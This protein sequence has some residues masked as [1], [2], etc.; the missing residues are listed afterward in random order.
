MREVYFIFLNISDGNEAASSQMF[1]IIL[2]RY[3]ADQE[4]LVPT[5]TG[6]PHLS[7]WANNPI[8][9]LSRNVALLWRQGIFVLIT[10]C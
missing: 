7:G 6:H 1:K 3:A 8:L 5:E 10:E 4:R 2:C 9:P